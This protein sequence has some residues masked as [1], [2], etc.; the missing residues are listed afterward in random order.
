MNINL[1][2]GLGNIGERYHGTRHNSGFMA[3]D[4]IAQ[5]HG[6]PPFLQKPRFKTLLSELTIDQYRVILAEPTTLMNNSGDAVRYL[7]D[8]Y[9]IPPVRVIIIHDEIDLDFGDVRSKTGGGSAGHKGVE[10][11]I[12]AIGKEFN[13]VRI[14]VANPNIKTIDTDDFVLSQFDPEEQKQLPQ[15]LAEAASKAVRFIKP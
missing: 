8:F 11:V 1:I 13:R 3:V 4:T 12:K 14:G 10:S 9:K 2:V 15:V 7:V 5:S 6:A